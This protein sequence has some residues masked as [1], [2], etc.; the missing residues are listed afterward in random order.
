MHYETNFRFAAGIFENGENR[1]DMGLQQSKT[2]EKQWVRCD[3]RV[4]KSNFGLA[5]QLPPSWLKSS[6]SP[7]V[8]P[9]T[10]TKHVGNSEKKEKM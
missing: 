1:W 3:K 4:I 5:S 2:T 8:S 9:N 10:L 7:S 6:W